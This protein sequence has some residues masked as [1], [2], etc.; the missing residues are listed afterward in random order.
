MRCWM[1]SSFSRR[2][3]RLSYELLIIR[4]DPSM[5]MDEGGHAGLRI[6]GNLTTGPRFV[7]LLGQ[8]HEPIVD[9]IRSELVCLN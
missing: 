9:G 1:P 6:R 5:L 3:A 2:S 4:A 8:D 7:H